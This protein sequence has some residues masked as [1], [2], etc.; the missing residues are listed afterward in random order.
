MVLT[1]AFAA[2]APVLASDIPGYRDVV[3]ETASTGCCV[4]PGRR[5]GARAGA[6]AARPGRPRGA[7]AWPRARASAPSDLRGPMWPPRSLDCYERAA[8]SRRPGEPRRAAPAVRLRPGARR[9]APPRIPPSDCRACARSGATAARPPRRTG[10]CQDRPPR[11]APA[12]STWPAWACWCSALQRI[13]VDPRRRLSLLA[14]KPGLLAAGLALMC[15]SMF[16]RALAWHAILIAAPTWRRAKRRDA[17]QGTFI[18]V[19]MSSTLPARLGEP[20][21]ALIVARRLGRAR[22]TLPVVLGTMVSQTLLNLLA[23]ALLGGGDAARASTPWTGITAL[24][25]IA[26]PRAR[27]RGACRRC[28]ARLSFPAPAS[29]ARRA[30]RRSR[31]GVRRSLLR[32]RD[33][34]RRVR[35][36]RAGGQRDRRAAGRLGAAAAEPA[37]CC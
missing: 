34:L 21:R 9:P 28:S 25:S 16:A 37:G 12:V 11:R 13:G 24:L 7:S 20:S 8:A 29:R 26:G 31:R 4:P 27:W 6:A 17:M 36:P 19:L 18:G 30:W 15:A 2:G 35:R 23:L 22:E 32:L 3:R 14:S 5:A 1:E 10:R 33:G